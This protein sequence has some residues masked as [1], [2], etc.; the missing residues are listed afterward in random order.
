MEHGVASPV[1]WSKWAGGQ[2][3]DENGS[4]VTF[5]QSWFPGRLSQ[6]VT[7]GGIK[8]HRL[9]SPGVGGWMSKI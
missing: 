9:S 4:F 5:A 7:E 3:V 6:C 1:V 2:E 8:Q